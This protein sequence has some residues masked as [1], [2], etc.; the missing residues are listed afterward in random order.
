M[1]KVLLK[2]RQIKLETTLERDFANTSV[3]EQKWGGGERERER[4]VWDTF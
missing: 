1:T 4:L 2:F 3:K